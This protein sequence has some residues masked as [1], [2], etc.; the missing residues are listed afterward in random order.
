MVM[1]GD[2]LECQ[3]VESDGVHEILRAFIVQNVKFRDAA[4]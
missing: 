1:W 3:T 4:V 2:K